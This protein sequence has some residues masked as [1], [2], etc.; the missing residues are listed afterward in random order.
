MGKSPI[1]AGVTAY[2]GGIEG[3]I[4]RRADELSAQYKKSQMR[5]EQDRMAAG[6]VKPSYSTRREGDEVV[7]QEYTTAGGRKDIGRGSAY[8]PTAKVAGKP[9]TTAQAFKR[10][11]QIKET[12]AGWETKHMSIIPPKTLASL[13]KELKYYSQY[14]PEGEGQTPDDSM[15]R[16]KNVVATGVDKK[17]GRRVIKYGDGTLVYSDAP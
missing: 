17:S 3:A 11:N 9:P 4:G 12:I 10:V 2:G 14:L 7:T 6:L 1:A 15:E 8:S 16:A 13:E 5:N